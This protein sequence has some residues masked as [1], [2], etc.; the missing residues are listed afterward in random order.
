M[1]FTHQLGLLGELKAAA[2]F[3]EIGFSIYTSISDGIDPF[4]FIAHK[5]N[6]L[7]KVQVKSTSSK[8]G[9]CNSYSITLRTVTIH[10]SKNIFTPFDPLKCDILAVYIEPLDTVC[11]IPTAILNNIGS[12]R[13]RETRS[14]IRNQYRSWII[15]EHTNLS[16]ALQNL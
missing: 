9:N 7:I 12:I 3:V 4:D 13:L 14:K 16:K 8:I 1:H 5:D 2:K 6:K 11:F 15:S 10:K